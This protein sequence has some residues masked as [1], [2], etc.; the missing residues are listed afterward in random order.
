MVCHHTIRFTDF[1]VI[2]GFRGKEEQNHLY[3]IG[4]SQLQFPLSK[5]NRDPSEAIDLAPYHPKYKHLFGGAEQVSEISK[6]EGL[7]TDAVSRLILSHYYYLAG[8]VMTQ[9][10]LLQVP[11]RWGGDWDRDTDIFDNRFNDLGHFELDGG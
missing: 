11:L 6:A 10:Q 1:G 8:V 4:A 2:K 3:R 9:A 5:H 7:S